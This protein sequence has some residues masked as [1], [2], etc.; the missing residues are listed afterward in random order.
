MQ[1]HFSSWPVL[2]A[3]AFLVASPACIVRSVQPWFQE[4]AIVFEDD[5]LGGWVGKG[6]DDKDVAMTFLRAEQ[7]NTY[8]VQYVSKDGQGTFTGRVA[9]FGGDHYLEFRPRKGAPGIDGIMLYRTYSVAYLEIGPDRL[10]VRTL[11]YG[12]VTEAA[13][14]D[15]LRDVKYVWDDE[16][17]LILVSKTEELQRFL[18]GLGRESDLFAPPMRLTRKK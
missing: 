16:N 14:L 1:R 18:L 3:V 6:M 12:A 11:N 15:R 5:L 13:K 2:L 4:D 7:A 17:E 9:K 10:V 8:V